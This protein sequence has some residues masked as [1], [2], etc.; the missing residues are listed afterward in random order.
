MPENLYCK[1]QLTLSK[2][3]KERWDKIRWDYPNGPKDEVGFLADVALKWP[4]TQ[5]LLEDYEIM[6]LIP[7][8]QE[9][10]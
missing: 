5:E 1:G 2:E 7:K 8:N 6:G 4:I 10:I 3:G 9:G